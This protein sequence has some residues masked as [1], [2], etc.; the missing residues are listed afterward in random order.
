MVQSLDVNVLLF[1]HFTKLLMDLFFFLRRILNEDSAE[2]LEFFAAAANSGM[3][4]LDGGM[5]GGA[6]GSQQGHR[7]RHE[8]GGSRGDQGGLHSRSGR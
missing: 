1:E 4:F 5:G 2:A 6:G 7:G 8:A 3:E